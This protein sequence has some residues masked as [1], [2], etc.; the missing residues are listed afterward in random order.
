MT[1]KLMR[2]KKLKQYDIAK[3]T[4]KSFK[5]FLIF[6]RWSEH[7]LSFVVDFL[8]RCFSLSRQFDF[9]QKSLLFSK[10]LSY[11]HHFLTA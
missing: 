9:S 10:H 6:V 11:Y 8:V 5:K 7:S 4:S 1:S 2:T 3:L